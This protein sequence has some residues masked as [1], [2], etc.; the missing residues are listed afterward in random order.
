MLLT[1]KT[2]ADASAERV[3]RGWRKG[4]LVCPSADDTAGEGYTEDDDDDELEEQISGRSEGARRRG[5]REVRMT[6]RAA[7][8]YS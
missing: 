3:L 5:R 2:C 4:G 1:R 7:K 8:V 6:T